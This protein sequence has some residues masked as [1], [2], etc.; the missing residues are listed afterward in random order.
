MSLAPARD[1]VREHPGVPGAA[2]EEAAREGRATLRGLAPRPEA[3]GAVTRERGAEGFELGAHEAHVREGRGKGHL[4]T[5]PGEG[6][7]AALRSAGEDFEGVVPRDV[8]RP[9]DASSVRLGRPKRPAQASGRRV[10]SVR[11]GRPAGRFEEERE[12]LRAGARGFLPRHRGGHAR[13]AI[14]PV[15]EAVAEAAELCAGEVRGVRRR[16]GGR[17]RVW[18]KGGARF[19]L[20]LL[21]RGLALASTGAAEA[22]DSEEEEVSEEVQLHVFPGALA[23]REPRE[24]VVDANANLR[25]RIEVTREESKR[26]QG[27]VPVGGVLLEEER[28][29]LLEHAAEVRREVV[30]GRGHDAA[31]ACSGQ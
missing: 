20:P 25:A 27:G 12:P 13:E 31:S 3:R 22:R 30:R 26:V 8:R 18:R 10:R 15:R 11:L 6:G 21:R 16:S 2:Q 14:R 24:L 19:R 28:L 23:S 17:G 29:H 7:D 1:A 4:V 5:R 9:G